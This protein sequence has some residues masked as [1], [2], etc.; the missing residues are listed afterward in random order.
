MLKQR[1]GQFAETR[2]EAFL[3]TQGLA[4]V[5]RN[6]RCRF[7]EIDL[8]MRERDTLVFVEVRLRN[9]GGF[10]DGFDS[11]TLSKQRRL[12]M[13]ARHYLATLGTVPPCRFD[14]VALQHGTAPAW[15]RNAFSDVG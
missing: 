8:I 1:S 4:P 2:A 11:V 13:A 5:A 7:G 3:K 12:I 15:M 9:H 10:G 6:W 14:V